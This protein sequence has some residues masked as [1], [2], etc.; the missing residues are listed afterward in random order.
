M[1][2]IEMEILF[3]NVRSSYKK[4]LESIE[5]FLFSNYILSSTSNLFA[6]G[7]IALS[8]KFNLVPNNS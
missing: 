1:G 3:Y 5:A 4:S 7:A 2:F 8:P 6:K